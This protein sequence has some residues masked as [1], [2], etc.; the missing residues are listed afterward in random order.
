MVLGALALWL[1]SKPFRRT[2]EAAYAEPLKAIGWGFVWWPSASAL[3]IV[4]LVFVL[5]GVLVGFLS[6]GSLLSFWFG[7]LG[8]VLLLAFTLFF[9][10]VFTAS[11][12]GCLCSAAG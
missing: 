10:M 6:T 8:L 4:P 9:F 3:L 1:L 11:K 12:I 5:V 7:T 2:V